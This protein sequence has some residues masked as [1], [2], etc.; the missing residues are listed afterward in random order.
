MIEYP[1]DFIAKLRSVYA[2]DNDVMSLVFRNDEESFK[3]L[4]KLL[5]TKACNSNIYNID[6]IKVVTWNLYIKQHVIML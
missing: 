2:L 1:R 4:G 5:K 3:E 6:L